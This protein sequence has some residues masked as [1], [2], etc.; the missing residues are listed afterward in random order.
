M[1]GPALPP[2]REP[3]G[4]PSTVPQSG[5]TNSGPQLRATDP[6]A[7]LRDELDAEAADDTTER[8]PPTRLGRLEP[9]SPAADTGMLLLARPALARAHPVGRAR[10]DRA[11]QPTLSDVASAAALALP[12]IVTSAPAGR[13][14]GRAR[15]FASLLAVA[16]PAR[17]AGQRLPGRHRRRAPLRLVAAQCSSCIAYGAELPRSPC[18]SRSPRPA[19]VGGAAAAL[20]R[21]GLAAGSDR[22]ASP[23]WSIGMV[24]SA[25]PAAAEAGLLGAGGS[26]A[27]V[28]RRG[29]TCAYITSAV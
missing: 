1:T 28:R 8:R 4:E 15:A 6:G 22:H 11:T 19:L 10:I 25:S 17:S 3:I 18:A 24:L 7:A 14:G 29:R 26:A 27:R 16:G 13:G 9:P 21:R 12:G 23:Y 2:P 5:T 20:R